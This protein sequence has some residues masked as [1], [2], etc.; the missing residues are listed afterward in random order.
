MTTFVSS[1]ANAGSPPGNAPANDDSERVTPCRTV[2]RV[3]RGLYWMSPA[4]TDT[5]RERRLNAYV[6]SSR[7]T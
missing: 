5:P 4:H 6:K 3:M 2:P 1:S 7:Q